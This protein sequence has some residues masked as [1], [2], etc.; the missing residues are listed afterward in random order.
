MTLRLGLRAIAAAFLLSASLTGCDTGP[1]DPFGAAQEAFANGEPRTALDLINEAIEADPGNPEIRMLAG[2]AAMALDNPDRAIAEFERIEEGAPQYSLARAKLA[3]AQVAGNYFQAAK[4]TLD[5]LVMDNAT[6]YVAKIGYAFAQGE[7]ES[8]FGV[9]EAGLERFP[10]DPNLIAIDADRLRLAGNVEAALARLEPALAIEPAVAQAHMLAGQM[11]LEAREPKIAE[12]HFEKV[13][14]VRPMQQTAM[15][16]MA[17]IARDRGDKQEA[18]N[19]INKANDSGPAHPIA[20]L[21]AAQMAYDAGDFARAFELIEMTPPSQASQPEFARLRGLID[22]GRNQ[23][24]MAALALGDYVEATGGDPKVR[25]ILAGSLAEQSK[26]DEAWAA[27]SPVIEHPQIDGTGLVLA[28][29]LAEETGRGD[30]ERIREKIAQRSEAPSIAEQMREAGGAIRAG[31]WAKADA[32][33]APLIEG[34]GKNNPALLNNAAAVKTKLGHHDE[35][36][37]LARRALEEAPGNP[38]IKDT[39]GWAIW[40]AGGDKGEA[41]TLIDEA[42]N[43]A[44]GNAEI[45]RHW[46]IVHA[47]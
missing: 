42:R 18:G 19:W 40:Q 8:V 37:L 32:I 27:I 11:R 26:F 10:N 23:H 13:L 3:E 43:G 28:L 25:Q 7:A 12:E 15:L 17:A 44:P 14:S 4:D 46:S 38:E 35:A 2:N 45:A 21:F 16:A 20:L 47:Q 9:L 34:A 1:S 39:L 41:R 24:A 22:A 29:R 30:A 6:A 36:V 33:Y 31:N 5:T